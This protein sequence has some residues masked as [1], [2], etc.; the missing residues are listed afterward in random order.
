MK[1]K[2]KVLVM[3]SQCKNGRL[4]PVKEYDPRLAYCEALKKMQVAD[5]P[6]YCDFKK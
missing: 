1:K 4:V 2:E 5:S 3:C 6:R